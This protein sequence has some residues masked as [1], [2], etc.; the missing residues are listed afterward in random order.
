M[1]T[2]KSE[3]DHGKQIATCS[4]AKC[5][6]ELEVGGFVILGNLGEMFCSYPCYLKNYI[7]PTKE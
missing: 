4:D 3:Y 6:H 2:A 1:S 7:L 5:D